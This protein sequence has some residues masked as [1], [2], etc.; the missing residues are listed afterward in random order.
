M[1]SEI[2]KELSFIERIYE[3]VDKKVND[4]TEAFP[5]FNEKI[6]EDESL[7][8]MTVGF[9]KELNREWPSLY[10]YDHDKLLFHADKTD[11]FSMEK[12]H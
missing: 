8:F 9:A 5:T 11:S 10:L 4:D 6:S 1:P 7:R 3:G 12:T 2:Q